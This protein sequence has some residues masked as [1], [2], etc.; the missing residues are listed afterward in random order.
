MLSEAGDRPAGTKAA[1]RPGTIVV[2]VHGDGRGRHSNF[3]LALHG[4]LSEHRPELLQRIVVWR[5]GTPPP[6]LEDIRAVVFFLADPISAYPECQADALQLAELARARNIRLLNPPEALDNSVKANQAKRWKQ[7][8]IPCAGG[9]AAANAEELAKVIKQ[10]R[11]PIILRSNDLHRQEGAAVCADRSA[12]TQ[13]A[14]GSP[15]FPVVALE[16]VDT[17][18]SWRRSRPDS[19]FADYYHK[20]RSMVFGS[21]VLN[22]HIFFSSEPIVG[23]KTSTFIAAHAGSPPPRITEMLEEDFAF[24]Q[25]PAEAAETMQ[26]AMRALGMDIAAIDYSTCADGSVVMWE[27]NPYFHLPHWTKALLPGP[28]RLPERIPRMWAALA[29]EFEALTEAVAHD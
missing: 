16:F 17:R 21:R 26:S 11:Y 14:A 4:Y 2:A 7:A 10:A 8:G 28:R 18:E 24:S 3:L 23:A 12:A 19:V 5:T 25:A 22:N 13:W 29:D 27:A 9:R 1:E 20:R 6:P 15:P